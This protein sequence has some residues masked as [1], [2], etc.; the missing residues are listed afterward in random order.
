MI[1]K[2]KWTKS[3]IVP[4]AQDFMGMM[5]N[6]AGKGKKGEAHIKFFEDNMVT[7]FARGINEM[8]HVKQRATEDF[9]KLSK[10]LPTIKKRLNKK[11]P[12]SVFTYDQAIRVKI[13]NDAGFKIPDI[14]KTEVK[15]L[16]NSVIS[17]PELLTFTNGLQKITRNKYVE[18]GQNWVA[19]TILSD[20]QKLTQFVGRK[21]YLSE[22]IEN[23][24]TIFSKENL[25]K[26]EA[27]QGSKFRES[28]EDM[29]Y[30]MET[31]SNRPTGGNRLTNMH[32]NFIN[33]SVGATMFL[34]MRSAILQTISAT[35]YINFAENNPVKA[36]KA[37]GNQKQYWKDFSYIWNSPM[38]KQRRAGLRYNVQEAELAAA[39]AGSK[40]KS[41]AAMAWLIK[42]GFTP[43]QVADSFAISAGGASYYRNRIGMYEKLGYSFGES[44]KKAW[45]DFQETTE[46]AQQS[47]RADLISQQQAS[48]LGRT[49][50]AWANTPMQYMRIQ[51][52]AARDIINGRGDFKANM[53]K[54]A[55][56]GFAQSILFA[57]LQNAMFSFGLDKEEDLDDKDF[58]NRLERVINTVADGQLRGM[59]TPGALLSAVKNTALEFD[60]QNEKG[61][62]GD[63]T[64]TI[65]QL[66]GY[67]PVL[68]SKLRKLYSATQTYKS[69]KDVIPEMGL[70]LNN[71]ANL[72]IGNAIEATTNVPIARAVMKIDNIREALDDR[73][74]SWQRIALL[75]GWSKWDV[76]AETEE[77]KEIKE[78]IKKE[79]KEFKIQ[80]KLIEKA[81]KAKEQEAINLEKQAKEK[82]EGKK[83]TCVAMSSSGQRCGLPVVGE[84]KYCTIH[85][86]VEQGTKEVQCKKIKSDGKQCKMKTKNK[87]GLCYYH[88]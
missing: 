20:V 74:Q 21:K 50:L 27:T 88:D 39:V 62:K 47:S 30:R 5:Q 19:E 59:G 22:W 1:G 57:G 82:E 44:R 42:K 12:N 78:K 72:A 83:V 84:G 9:K 2:N 61:Y 65:L 77:V 63:H 14:S 18:P 49:I 31:G 34:N 38:L 32:M 68:G 85:Q 60:K 55:Y 58:N 43:T 35:N 70:S 26:I 75:M 10:E 33:G 51:E 79:K 52:K 6:F 16:V 73:N 4:G 67:S 29:L 64:K 40:N 81:E 37:F 71:P 66:T 54:I 25:N 53:S 48:P 86:K 80:Q 87:S 28:L 17:N 13:W 45:L 76:G 15:E 8:N 23:K 7:P 36:A 46:K 11:I 41:K 3:I 56:Y 69:N 24:N